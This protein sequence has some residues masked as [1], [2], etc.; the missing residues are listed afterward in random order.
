MLSGQNPLAWFGFIRAVKRNLS[1]KFHV[2]AVAQS[3]TTKGFFF[4]GRERRVCFLPRYDTLFRMDWQ[5][6]HLL[7]SAAII[8][9]KHQAQIMEQNG[10]NK[11]LPHVM[12]RRCTPLKETGAHV[13]HNIPP[14]HNPLNAKHC[15][16]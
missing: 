12:H 15:R 14:H 5:N 1:T 8:W 9:A 4:V 2:T 7:I 11:V 3:L 13:D 16:L 6:L 10:V